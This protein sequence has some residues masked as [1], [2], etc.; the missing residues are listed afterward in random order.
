MSAPYGYTGDATLGP[1]I[2]RALRAVVD[3]EM[4]LG[5]VDLGLV[6]TVRVDESDIAVQMTMTS[7]ACPVIDLIV[8]D[9][10]DALRDIAGIS[11]GV[12]VDVVWEPPW[13][14]SHMSE[15]ARYAMGWD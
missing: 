13:D 15:A 10:Q 3:P 4:A 14:P 5:I 7:A 8:A 12:A 2:D 11:R 6:R 9:V 1:R